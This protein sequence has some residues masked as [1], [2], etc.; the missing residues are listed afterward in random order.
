V[1][2][3][4]LPFDL[5]SKS[6]C[7]V[8]WLRQSSSLRHGV[9]QGH[10]AEQHLSCRRIQA[11]RQKQF[12][13]DKIK[14]K[15]NLTCEIYFYRT[16]KVKKYPQKMCIYVETYIQRDVYNWCSAGVDL[17]NNLRTALIFTCRSQKSKKDWR[18]DCIFC[19]FGICVRKIFM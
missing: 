18:L 10:R 15:F 8:R 11:S 19:T 4:L 6:N 14:L 3:L 17:T 1:L 12:L 5:L 16:E 9:C 2:L 7:N 13:C